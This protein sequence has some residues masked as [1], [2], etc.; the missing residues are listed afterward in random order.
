M[1]VYRCGGRELPPSR[2]ASHLEEF[3]EFFKETSGFFTL[4][5]REARGYCKLLT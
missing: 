4:Q 3:E 5:L 2:F 1:I